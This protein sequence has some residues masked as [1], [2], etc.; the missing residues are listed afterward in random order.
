MEDIEHASEPAK[1]AMETRFNHGELSLRILQLYQG[2]QD[3]FSIRKCI[4]LFQNVTNVLFIISLADYDEPVI[5]DVP[6]EVCVHPLMFLS[7]AIC[8][9]TRALLD[10]IGRIP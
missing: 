4:P 7:P 10:A 9:T 6:Q 1:G 8:L 3:W 5:S 2:Q